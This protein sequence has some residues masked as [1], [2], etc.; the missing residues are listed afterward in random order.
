[1][2]RTIAEVAPADLVELSEIKGIGPAKL[3][4][5]GPQFLAA[6]KG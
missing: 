3:D 6:V 2:L 4:K 1:M 5:Y